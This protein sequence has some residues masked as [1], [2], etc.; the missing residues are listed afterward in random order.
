MAIFKER[1][2]SLKNALEDAKDM[3]DPVEACKLLRKYFGDDFPVPEKKETA[4]VRN[5]A[6]SYS[7]SSG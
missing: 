1:L 3:V 4:E 2:E 7:S 6:F 5:R